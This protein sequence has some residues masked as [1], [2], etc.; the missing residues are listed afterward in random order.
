MSYD[1]WLLT[2]KLISLSLALLGFGGISWVYLTLLRHKERHIT[3]RIV[4]QVLLA[5]SFLVR[6]AELLPK[7]AISLL[8]IYAGVGTV[9]LLVYMV[10]FLIETVPLKPVLGKPKKHRVNA[11]ILP[12]IPGI[13]A[14][15]FVLYSL[16]RKVIVGLSKEYTVLFWAW[17]GFTAFF[18]LEALAL[19]GRQV[20]LTAIATRSELF[21]F[22]I[23]RYGILLVS[24]LTLLAWISAYI[25]FSPV[26]RLSLSVWQLIIFLCLSLSAGFTFLTIIRVEEQISV[27]L[28]KN[29]NL[30]AFSL[31]ETRRTS[32]DYV[33]LLSEKSDLRHAILSD[34]ETAIFE[35]SKQILENNSS[36]DKLLITDAQGIL[37]V[38][39]SEVT[40][41]RTSIT[42][43][44]Y[45]KKVMVDNVLSG[46][47]MVEQGITG[48][49][50]LSF[51]LAEPVFDD[52]KQMIGIITIFK[53]IN[54][55]YLDIIKE[56]SGQELILYVNGKRSA[57]TLVDPQS[58]ARYENVPLVEETTSLTEISSSQQ[59]GFASI[60]TKEYLTSISLLDGNSQIKLMVAI[61]RAPV[62][63]QA[64][65]I[66]RMTYGGVIAFCL[67]ALIP[68]ASIARRMNAA[69]SA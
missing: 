50:R 66:I 10:S 44:A 22:D 68:T 2:I 46:G 49:N 59:V 55:E 32:K 17:L 45:I 21:W 7:S 39:S 58:L 11:Y 40:R 69:L 26:L 8:P 16:A 5:I 51:V 3:I 23:V 15:I 35:N 19:G 29:S 34:D 52:K 20:L 9:G 25:E 63:E 28:S 33:T 62:V 61:E 1:L 18:V 37:Y 67:L 14:T 41:R 65:E 30:V 36:I 13:V 64:K 57:S 31:D 56:K 27:L 54:D 6:I 42:D 4:G 12:F 53:Y 48:N 43:N 24:G 38:D 60:L 47:L